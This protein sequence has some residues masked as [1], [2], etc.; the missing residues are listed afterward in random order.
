MLMVFYVLFS[1]QI[2]IVGVV[3]IQQN[4]WLVVWEFFFR[5]IVKFFIL[6]YLK[7]LIRNLY[8]SFD[9]QYDLFIFIETLL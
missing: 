2:I 1:F 7:K 3:A 5:M 9:F 4:Y 6:R 8:Y